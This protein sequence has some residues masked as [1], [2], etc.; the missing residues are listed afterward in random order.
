MGNQAV[1]SVRPGSFSELMRIL[2]VLH[3]AETWNHNGELLIK[4]GISI[5]DLITS[6][7]DVLEQLIAYG[8]DRE[9]AYEIMN[10]VRKGKG[11]TS[12]LEQTMKESNVPSWYAVS[13]KKILYLY[14]KS[15]AAEYMALYWKLAYYYLYYPKEYQEELNFM[16]HD[17]NESSIV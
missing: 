16:H 9:A 8:L 11:L 6:S 4:D 2:A 17:R 5:R 10:R 12:E 1:S 3:G 15:Q 14:S 13:C 7:D